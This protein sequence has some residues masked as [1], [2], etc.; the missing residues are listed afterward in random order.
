MFAQLSPYL[1]YISV[2]H[3]D[4]TVFNLF[5][6]KYFPKCEVFW[7]SPNFRNFPN[8]G[9]W[10]IRRFSPEIVLISLEVFPKIF[11]FQAERMTQVETFVTARKEA[12]GQ[13]HGET[14]ESLLTFQQAIF[15][16]CK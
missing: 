4:H 3:D 10:A 15:A 13:G 16:M 8:K 2:P 14:Y 11:I 7:K 9:G 6:I 5:G 12:Q 1:Y